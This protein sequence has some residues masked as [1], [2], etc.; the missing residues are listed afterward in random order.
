MVIRG[1]IQLKLKMRAILLVWLTFVP[2]SA[3]PS[4]S[5]TAL[6]E[7]AENQVRGKDFKAKMTLTVVRGDDQRTI[8]V[9]IWTLTTEMALLKILNPLK[10]RF[11]GNLRTSGALWQY[12]PNVD[13]VI[14]VPPSLMGQSWMGSDFSNDDLV[15]SSSWSRDYTHQIIGE[16]KGHGADSVKIECTRKKDSPVV[17]NKMVIVVRKSDAALIRHEF[18]NERN[19]LIKY[20]VGSNYKSSN[21]HTVPTHLEMLTPKKPQNK[22]VME[23]Q[24]ISFD[25]GIS[26]DLFSQDQLKKKIFN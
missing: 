6:I 24:E 10:D 2:S 12:L 5:A 17:W 3:F 18:Y 11:G 4:N 13:R 22:T 15:R 25:S 1:N 21:G 16:E 26:K 19:E 14:R 23:Y 8:E 9:R 20:M 7:K